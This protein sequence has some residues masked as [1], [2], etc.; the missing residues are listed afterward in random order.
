MVAA[1]LLFTSK[2]H[3]MAKRKSQKKKTHRRRRVGGL[4]LN[5]SSPLVMLGSVALGYL[6]GGAINSAL[7]MLVP[8]S[9]K[10]QSYTGKVL[11]GGQIGVGT[12]LVM[13]KGKKS[14]LKTVAGGLLAGAGIKRAMVVFAPGTTD[15][16]GG[17]GAVPV[18]GAY[19]TPGQIGYGRKVAGYGSVPVLG[20]YTPNSSLTG[21]VKVMGSTSASGYGSG[22]GSSYMG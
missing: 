12:L 6:G 7:N 16:L 21:A 8:A 11:A 4:A 10:T 1:L 14:I 19:A 18:L 17:Y 15:T 9:M 22:Y 3:V 20:A 2:I 13:G 5:A